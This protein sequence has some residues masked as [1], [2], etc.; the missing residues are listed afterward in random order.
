MIFSS[1]LLFDNLYTEI[2]GTIL[3][4]LDENGIQ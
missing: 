1:I 2:T 3:I 4:W